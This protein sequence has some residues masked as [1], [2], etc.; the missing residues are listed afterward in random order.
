MADPPDALRRTRENLI[1]FYKLMTAGM[2]P[3]DEI[4]FVPVLPHLLAATY[5]CSYFYVLTSDSG[6]ALLVDFGA[7]SFALFQP[8]NKHFEDGERVRFME[9]SLER[10][11]TQY[12]VQ[13]I[14]AVLPS[15]YHDDHINGIPYL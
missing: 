1:S 6:K 7:P 3:A 11:R 14:Q 13:H 4:D 12:G 9:H 5:A 2:L 8:A 10:L 15:H